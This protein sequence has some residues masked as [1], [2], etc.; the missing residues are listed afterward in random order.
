M[1]PRTAGKLRLINRN[2]AG[3]PESQGEAG[4]RLLNFDM[5]G[6]QKSRMAFYSPL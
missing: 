3:K 5:E 1:L 6:S 4:C 2:Y